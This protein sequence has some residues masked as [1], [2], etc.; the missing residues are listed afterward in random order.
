MCGLG[1]MEIVER[2]FG[3]TGLVIEWT[4]SDDT[5]ISDSGSLGD[6]GTVDEDVEHGM[7]RSSA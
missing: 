5:H 3:S 2:P 7:G 4:V 6:G 1:R